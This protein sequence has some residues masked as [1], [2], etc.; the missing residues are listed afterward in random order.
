MFEDTMGHRLFSLAE[1]GHLR[2]EAIQLFEQC[3]TN[4]EA[5]AMVT[6]IERQL[7]SDIA[8]DI[9]LRLLSL[10]EY[11]FDVRERVVTALDEGY[12]VDISSLTPPAALDQYHLLRLDDVIALIERKHPA[13]APDDLAMLRKMIDASLHMAAQLYNDIQLTRDIY[14]LVVDW[15]EALSA[16]IARQHWTR[17]PVYPDTNESHTYH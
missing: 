7:V 5:S 15:A 1:S 16:T 13:L 14:N 10:R 3:L 9:Q 2:I 11:H 12:N 6:F 8:N 17:S 4:G